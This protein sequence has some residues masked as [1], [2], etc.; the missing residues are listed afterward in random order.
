MVATFI[1]ELVLAGYTLIRYKSN[2][3]RNLAIILL[4]LLA[5]FQLAEFNT[6]GRF[7]LQAAAWS[8]IGFVAITLLPPFAIHLTQ[9]ISR[10][11][12]P[13]I[14]WLA[15]ATSVPWLI[16]FIKPSTFSGHVCAGNY[17][18]FQLASHYGG[19]YFAYY[20]FW[21]FIG[22]GLA[23]V[24]AFKSSKNS[25]R[26]SLILQA[27]GYLVF[28][29]PTAL[30]NTVKPSTIAGLPSIMCGFALLYALILIFG[31]LPRQ[32]TKVRILDK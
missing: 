26:E 7:G 12:H 9:A 29:L 3:V 14:H 24:Y 10:K 25:I 1:I 31:I 20:Y 19:F 15:Y 2:L 30:T 11:G 23:L 13:Q 5:I 6:C 21:L 8:S 27:T 32:S 22:I 16:F 4:V 28:L 18:I 17:A